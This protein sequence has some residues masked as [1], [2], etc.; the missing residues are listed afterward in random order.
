MPEAP[1][2]DHIVELGV[3][4]RRIL[5]AVFISAII[6]SLVP[7]SLSPYEPLASAL[8]RILIAQTVPESVSFMGRTYTVQLAQFSPFAGFNVIILSTILLGVLGASPVIAREIAG[9]LEP[10]LYR[11]EKEALRRY[12]LAAFGLFALGVAFAY[13]IFIPW[14]MR[15]LLLMSVMVAG[16]RGLVAFADVE[17]LFKLIVELMLASGIMFEVPLVVYVLIVYEIIGIE[18]FKGDGMKYAFMASVILGAIISPDPTGIGM[19]MIAIP[20][21][22][23]LYI[24]VKLAERSLAKR[25]AKAKTAVLRESAPEAGLSPARAREG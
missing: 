15:F 9:Y 16:D 23:L 4:L 8:P 22:T 5:T 19:M 6:L 17:Y 3:R 13:F 25:Q 21:F 24:A 14:I 10:A 12:S 2:W 11:H 1:L 18:R 7:Y 20:Y